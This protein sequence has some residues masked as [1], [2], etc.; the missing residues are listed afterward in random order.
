MQFC[1]R[2][3]WVPCFLFLIEYKY[4]LLHEIWATTHVGRRIQLTNLFYSLE[5][6]WNQFFTEKKKF[7]F[8]EYSV[9]LFKDICWAS[10]LVDPILG[11]NI[12]ESDRQNFYFQKAYISA[13]RRQTLNKIK[14]DKIA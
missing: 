8:T 10:I 9:I 12:D 11:I 3:Y 14:M 4:L 7:F 6:K 1:S 13:V 2:D 5:K